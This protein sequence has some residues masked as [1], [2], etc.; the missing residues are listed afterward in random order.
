MKQKNV[1][2]TEAVEM[3]PGVTRKTLAYNKNIMLCYITL[4]KGAKIP[5]H[6]HDPS[7]IGYVASGR[8]RFIGA[9]E[10][11]AFEAGPGDA[12]VMDPNVEHGAE[13]LEDTVLVEAFSPSRP[14][15]ED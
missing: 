6:H 14:E 11:D 8:A 4:K 3:L 7:Q 5:L 9:S 12:Y 2:T 13:A 1:E 15:Y 10:A